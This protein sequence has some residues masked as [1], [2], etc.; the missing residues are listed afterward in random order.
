MIFSTIIEIVEKSIDRC[1]NRGQANVYSM[2][3]A[4]FIYKEKEQECRP[5]TSVDWKENPTVQ[6]TW[7]PGKC[8]SSF[9]F[10]GDTMPWPET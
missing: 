9:D 10:E 2:I 8:V 7:N 3:M 1:K 5:A 6:S 4:G